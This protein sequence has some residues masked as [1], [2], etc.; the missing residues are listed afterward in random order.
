MCK[1]LRK[2]LPSFFFKK[3]E[4]AKYFHID[5]IEYWKVIERGIL[6]EIN[7]YRKSLEKGKV[8]ADLNCYNEAVIR[9]K[10]LDSIGILTHDGVTLSFDRLNKLGL[11][12]TAE[13]LGANH[14]NATIIVQAWSKSKKHEKIMSSNTYK[15]CG[16]SRLKV[17]KHHFVCVIFAS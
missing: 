2:I 16:V 1:F 3:I 4:K 6:A 12:H 8:S 5:N 9:T 15:Y 14:V 7:L 17:G 10:Y 13:I 11:K